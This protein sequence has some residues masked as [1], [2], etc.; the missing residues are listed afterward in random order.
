M[1]IHPLI[2]KRKWL[3]YR[4]AGSGSLF[5]SEAFNEV[6]TPQEQKAFYRL[7]GIIDGLY[8]RWDEQTER[9]M[10]KHRSETI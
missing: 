6:L 10:K 5:K 4:L 7:E 1:P 2:K 8:D 3:K 9:V